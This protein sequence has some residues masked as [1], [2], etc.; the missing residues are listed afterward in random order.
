M[1]QKL[2]LFEKDGVGENKRW[3]FKTVIDRLM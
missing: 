3:T 2:K 1:M